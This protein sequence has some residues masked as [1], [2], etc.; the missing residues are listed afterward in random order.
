MNAQVLRHPE[1]SPRPEVLAG[2][3]VPGGMGAD[4]AVVQRAL[5][6]LLQQA[7]NEQVN[8]QASNMQ[9]EYEYE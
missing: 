5:A 1:C 3:G 9:Y 8:E 4:R 6:A 2:G 7:V